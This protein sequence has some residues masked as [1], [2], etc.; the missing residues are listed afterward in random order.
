MKF[1]LNAALLALPFAVSIVHAHGDASPSATSAVA[2]QTAWGVAG[3]AGD[4]S[5][6]LTVEMDDRMRFV[7]DEISVA[8]G[9]TVRLVVRNRGRLLHELVLGTHDELVKHAALM[10]KFPSMA[11]DEP[12]MIHVGPGKSAEIV[13]HFNRAGSFE[14]ACLIPGHYEAGMRGILTVVPKKGAVQ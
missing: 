7:P 2:E 13:W 3:R 8:E 1:L 14:F 12:Y 5:R 9:E 6:T 10:A 4:V 11:H